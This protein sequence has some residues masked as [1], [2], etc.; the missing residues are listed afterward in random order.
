[1]FSVSLNKGIQQSEEMSDTPQTLCF[2]YD[3]AV[4]QIIS[5]TEKEKRKK[6]RAEY[7]EFWKQHLKQNNCDVGERMCLKQIMIE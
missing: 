5:G 7:D 6:V 4:S 3:I 2:Q 1:M